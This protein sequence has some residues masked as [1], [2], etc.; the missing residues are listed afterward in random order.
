LKGWNGSNIWEQT[1]TNRNSIQ[2]KIKSRLKSGNACNHS[3]Q[4]LLSS[5]LLSKNTKIKIY[6]TIILRV[7]LYGCDTWSLTLRDE[8]RLRVYENR[9]LRRLFGPKRDEVTGEWGRLHNQILFG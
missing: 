1:Q 3:E 5:S 9:V 2:E 6:R 8:H 7:V 4:D